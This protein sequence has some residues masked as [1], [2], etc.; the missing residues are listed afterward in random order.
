MEWCSGINAGELGLQARGFIE[1]RYSF[2]FNDTSHV[3]DRA[4][5]RD[6]KI[7]SNA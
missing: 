4:H 7:M 5:V 2:N 3:K 6:R 1:T